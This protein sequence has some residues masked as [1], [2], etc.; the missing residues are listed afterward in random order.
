MESLKEKTG[1]PHGDVKENRGV[2]GVKIKS[3]LVQCRNE[4]F[5]K[6]SPQVVVVMCDLDRRL[7]RTD[8]PKAL[9]QNLLMFFVLVSHF[10]M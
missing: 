1:T 5:A 4:R 6:I 3:G 10:A 2:R 8:G 7:F 9:I